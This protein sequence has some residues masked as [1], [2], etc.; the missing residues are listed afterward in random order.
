[1]C[2]IFTLPPEIVKGDVKFELTHQSLHISYGKG[3]D[4]ITTLLDG[5]LGGMVEM[6]SSVWTLL[7]HKY[8]DNIQSFL[9]HNFFFASDLK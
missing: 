1:M 8:A 7:D 6:S 5:K 4:N 3:A 2:V 9:K